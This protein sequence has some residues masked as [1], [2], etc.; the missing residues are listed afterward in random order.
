MIAH[1]FAVILYIPPGIEKLMCSF[2]YTSIFF[3]SISTF[4]IFNLLWEGGRV[5]NNNNDNNN[6][7]IVISRMWAMQKV[8]V[9]PVVVGG[10]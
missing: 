7:F 9:I 2:N 3:F 8:E 5:F 6:I 1:T 4:M 10:L